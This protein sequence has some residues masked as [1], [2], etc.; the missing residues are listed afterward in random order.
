MLML[1]SAQSGA[2]GSTSRTAAYTPVSGARKS[3]A[4]P[5][6][7]FSNQVGDP[8]VGRHGPA[9]HQDR[10][11]QQDRARDGQS[12]FPRAHAGPPADQ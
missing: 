3:K 7:L 12:R 6:A 11:Q 9:P 2:T 10:G 5:N 1:W 8:E 4:D